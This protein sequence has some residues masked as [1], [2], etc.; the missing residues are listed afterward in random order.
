VIVLDIRRKKGTDQ[1]D[2]SSQISIAAGRIYQQGGGFLTM[3]RHL[4]LSLVTLVLLGFIAGCV[5]PA[6]VGNATR[7]C[8]KDSDLY[9]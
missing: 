2:T 9:S 4:I 8:S 5:T 3:K 1:S 6:P 7:I